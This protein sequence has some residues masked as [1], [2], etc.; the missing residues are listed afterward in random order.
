M[1]EA[2]Q[3]IIAKLKE[4]YNQIAD[5]FSA[6]R[7]KPWPEME[8]FQRFVAPGQKV[9]DLGC[10]NGR[11]YQVLAEKSIEYYGLDLSENLIDVAK[12]TFGQQENLHWSVG[13]MTQPLNFENKFFDTVFLIAS[14]N[15]I[16]TEKL[17]QQVL[18]EI[19]RITK[20][21]GWLVMTNW[22]LRAWHLLKKYRLWHLLWG[23]KLAGLNRGDTWIKW[24]YGGREITERYY[25]A[26]TV[27]EIKKLAKSEGWQ[28]ME[29]YYSSQGERRGRFSG[30]NLISVLRKF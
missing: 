18:A 27:G 26:F 11:L 20:P 7:Q 14:F 1:S 4:D 9:L 10:G 21:G 28:V 23:G 25:H 6:T 16:P 30:D 3:K 5:G 13:D 17:R 15:H 29:Q 2:G 12:E 8:E 24:S 22:N 19:Y